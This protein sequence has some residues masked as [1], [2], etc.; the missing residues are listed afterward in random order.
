MVIHLGVS[1]QATHQMEIGKRPYGEKVTLGAKQDES[2]APPPFLNKI[3]PEKGDMKKR[4]HG[5]L[6]LGWSRI[7]HRQEVKVS[8]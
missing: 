8:D 5:L 2:Y 6:G 3:L 7:H 1:R 4:C